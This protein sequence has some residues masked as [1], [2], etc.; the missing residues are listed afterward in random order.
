[1]A[2]TKMESSQE[3]ITLQ[4]PPVSGEFYRSPIPLQIYFFK[5]GENKPEVQIKQYLSIGVPQYSYG[6]PMGHFKLK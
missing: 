3:V 1:V 2:Y 4:C 6:T 5:S